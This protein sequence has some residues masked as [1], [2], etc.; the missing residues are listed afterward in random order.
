MDDALF[1]GRVWTRGQL[2]ARVSGVRGESIIRCMPHPPTPL[3][4]ANKVCNSPDD[5]SY[6]KSKEWK[7]KETNGTKPAIQRSGLMES[8][9]VPLA[10]HNI[11]LSTTVPLHAIQ[12]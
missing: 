12:I 3:C 4:E 7:F 6:R 11:N 9:L 8:S 5:R 10:R 2:D 1:I